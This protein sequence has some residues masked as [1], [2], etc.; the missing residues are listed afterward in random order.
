MCD[1]FIE[2]R[3]GAA[4]ELEIQLNE[5]GNTSLSTSTSDTNSILR[6]FRPQVPVLPPKFYDNQ[7]T[8]NQGQ[9]NP[10][11]IQCGPEPRWLLICARTQQSV[12]TLHQENICS[13]SS[14]RELFTT[15]R[16]SY[17]VQR[18]RWKQVFSLRTIRSIKFARVSLLIINAYKLVGLLSLVCAV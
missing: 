16:E 4:S 7:Q 1:D 13:I 8:Q 3:P 12:P 14:D 18:G 11:I 15:M 9:L 5:N 10:T 6:G 2:L 17:L